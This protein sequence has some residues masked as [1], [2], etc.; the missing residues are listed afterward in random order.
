MRYGTLK[1]MQFTFSISTTLPLESNNSI[2]FKPTY[3]LSPQLE[4]TF[5]SNSR[6]L[7][8]SGIT[9]SLFTLSFT[10]LFETELNEA[11]FFVVFLTAGFLTEVSKFMESL[12]IGFLRL[13]PSGGPG[14]QITKEQTEIYEKA[15]AIKF[16]T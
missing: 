15:C 16:L 3:C 1:K 13:F 2:P 9:N 5:I 7:G 12:D 10:L 8:S 11:C 6:P 14:I 4:N